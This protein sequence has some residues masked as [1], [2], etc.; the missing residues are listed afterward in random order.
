MTGLDREEAHDRMS[1]LA[2]TGRSLRHRGLGVRV[3][4][5]EIIQ[6]I[7]R[8]RH[9]RVATGARGLVF[10]LERRVD[11]LVMDHADAVPGD[12]EAQG[13]QGGPGRDRR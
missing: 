10:K 1:D 9:Q 3:V 6:F 5:A 2:R 8:P 4:S 7:P 11:D 13:W 12:N